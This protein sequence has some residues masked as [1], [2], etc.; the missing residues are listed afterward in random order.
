MPQPKKSSK[1][2]VKKIPAK[3]NQKLVVNGSFEGLI[4]ELIKP[5]TKIKK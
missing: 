5:N 1:K 4:K 2:K 3:Y